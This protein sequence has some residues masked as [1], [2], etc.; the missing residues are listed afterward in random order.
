MESASITET[1]GATGSD[2]SVCLKEGGWAV[3]IQI[4]EQL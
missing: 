1:T 3:T 4:E 2:R